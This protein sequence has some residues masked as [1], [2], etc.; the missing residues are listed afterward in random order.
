MLTLL[1]AAAFAQEAP[2]IV[3]GDTTRDYPQVVTLF[4][5]DSTGAGYN[6]CSGTLIA[7]TW[8]VTAA[9]CVVAMDDNEGMGLPDLIVIVGYDLNTTAGVQDYAY[10][11]AW[12]A[13]A[14]YDDQTLHND[15][16]IVELATPITSIDFMPVHKTA[17]R[18]GEVGDDFRYV[19]WGITTD[20]G[21]DSSKK[22]TADIPLYDFDD[23]F[24]YGYDPVDDQNVCSGD[25][26]GA[27]LKI[28]STG[29]YELAGVNSFVADDD[30]TPCDGGY[31]GGTR[32]DKYIDWLERYTPVYSADELAGDADT[33]TD[34]DTDTDTD[35][36]TDT[37]TDTDTDSD[38][39]TDTDAGPSSD[40]AGDPDRP[41]AVGEDYASD[42]LFCASTPAGSG[43]GLL[44]LAGLAAVR[45]RARSA[46]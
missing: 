37:D 43:F 20:N 7:P 15:I 29:G 3:N 22:H 32:V 42:S 11:S 31:T 41:D 30:S 12:H 4:A 9:H 13:H 21:T 28:L 1:A 6:F 34:S 35:S 38:S 18:E 36:D 10:A 26:G 2:P 5:A 25:S 24:V 16:G 8:V 23:Y 46:C 40:I 33:D 19:G 14:S 39:D 44:A 27:V 17:I 45:R